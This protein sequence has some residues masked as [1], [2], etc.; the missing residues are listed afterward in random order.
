MRAITY[1]ASAVA[2]VGA[3]TAT[4]LADYQ[5][6]QSNAAPAAYTSHTLTFDEAGGPGGNFDQLVGDEWNAEMGVSFSVGVGGGGQVT[7]WGAIYGWPLG[8]GWSLM[9]AFGTTITWDNPIRSLA[10]GQASWRN[11]PASR[12][13]PEDSS[14]VSKQ[15]PHHRPAGGRALQEILRLPQKHGS[16]RA[17]GSGVPNLSRR[18]CGVREPG[19]K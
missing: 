15:K 4:T 7:D 16:G 6:I 13:S 2:A 14:P 1:T 9:G 5:I 18:V 10:R 17:V 11:P 12:P 3:L 19:W 8:N